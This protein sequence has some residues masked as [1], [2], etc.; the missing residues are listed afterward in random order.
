MLL[1]KR[2]AFFAFCHFV[3]L[4]E[5]ELTKSSYVAKGRPVS[6]PRTFDLLQR[7][8]GKI[9]VRK[10]DLLDCEFGILDHHVVFIVGTEVLVQS[11][12][13]CDHNCISDFGFGS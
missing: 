2:L 7:S 9:D 3:R 8:F 12:D 10:P 6:Q 1:G 5:P 11:H 4:E 13:A